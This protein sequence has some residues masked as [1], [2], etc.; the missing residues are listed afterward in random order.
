[1]SFVI[2]RAKLFEAKSDSPHCFLRVYLLAKNSKNLNVKFCWTRCLDRATN[3][4]G[5]RIADGVYVGALAAAHNAEWLAERQIGAILNL[6]HDTSGEKSMCL[7]LCLTK[8]K[9]NKRPNKSNKNKFFQISHFI[10][11]FFLK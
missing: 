4:Q 9:K 6:C 1:M 8:K 3:D 10:I 7:F 11:I 5:K 2:W